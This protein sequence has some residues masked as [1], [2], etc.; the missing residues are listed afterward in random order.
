MRV[1]ELLNAV[2]SWLES[3]DNEAMMLAEHDDDSL[4][5]TAMTCFEAAQVLRKG[6]SE[7]DAIE[8]HEQSNLSSESIDHVVELA[9]AFDQSDDENLHKLASVFDELLLSISAPAGSVEQF[10]SAQE[11]KMNEIK[12][13]YEEARSGHNKKLGDA[14][15]D[16]KS[17]PYYKEYLPMEAPLSSRSCP[18]HAGQQ[19]AR[20][21]DHM[22]QCSLDK[23]V[24]NFQS[25]YTN[26]KGEKVPGGD[27]SLQTEKMDMGE[28]HAMFDTRDSRL[29]GYQR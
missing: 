14:A 20:V 6:A 8:P 26:E 22:W 12:K 13:Q 23:K 4:T 29:N 11:E 27:V 3:S 21:G 17:S 25:G 2:A 16:I 10:K 15:K 1:A 18:D 7:V 19:M 9:Q 5:T 28:G 24:F